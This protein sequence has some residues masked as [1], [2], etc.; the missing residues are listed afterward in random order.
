[1]ADTGAPWN[2]PYVTP[3]D[4]PRVFPAADEAQAL[5]IAAGLS[6]AGGLKQVVTTVKD[7]TFS[8]TST[9][10]VDVTGLSATI[11]PTSASSRI[12]VL[13]HAPV[14]GSGGTGRQLLTL[15][16]TANAILFSPDTP[17]SRSAA[18]AFTRQ[19]NA[20]DGS[21]MS[22]S[23]VHSPNTTSPYVYKV[24]MLVSSETGYVNRTGTDANNAQT[25]RS[26]ATI[27]LLEVAV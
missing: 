4:N 25:A 16:D 13:V 22:F 10:F 11:T 27:T 5:A 26:I 7:D 19:H 20:E 2:I 14:G 3:T 21:P 18:F 15:T 12:L 6:A 17:G 8:T 24:R 9:S 1:M 23:F